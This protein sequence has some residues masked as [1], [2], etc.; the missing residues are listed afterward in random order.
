MIRPIILITTC[1]YRLEWNDQCR[2]TWLK[3]WGSL[4][5]YRFIFGQGYMCSRSDEMNFPVDDSYNGL[6]A[7]IQASHKWAF[8]Q[9]YTH[10]LKTDSDMY[11]HIPRLLRSGF[12]KFSYS[13][14]RYYPEFV[15]GAA[16]WLDRQATEILI[17]APL[18]YPGSPGGDDIWVGK[19]MDANGIPAHHDARY[20][21]GKDI[22]WDDF[23]SLHTPDLSLSMQDI[24]NKVMQ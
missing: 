1:S 16:Y 24:H 6:P 20:H 5:P 13:G 21:I 19:I 10:I 17:N 11:I 2:E 14:N 22:P 3:E 23:I 7:K 12:E 15:M 8:D 18:P 9:E 4:I